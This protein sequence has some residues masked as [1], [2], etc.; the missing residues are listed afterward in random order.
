[1]RELFGPV[2]DPRS[3]QAVAALLERPICAVDVGCRDGVRQQWRALGSHGVLIGFEADSEECAR[4]NA[5]ASEAGSERY[6]PL[7]LAARE[8]PATLHLTADPESASLYPPNTDAIRR[9]PELWRHEPHGSTT[10]Q[11]TTLDRWAQDRPVDVLKVDVQG[12]ELDVLRGGESTLATTRAL[13]VEVEFQ[14]LYV[15]QPLFGDV[16]AFLREHGFV[17]WRLRDIAHCGLTSVGRDEAAFVVGERAET[18]RTGGRVS[19]A[20]A[21]YVRSEA[22]D[23][24]VR[25]DWTASARD[26][27]A[28]VLFDLPELVVLNLERAAEGAQG[29]ARRTLRRQLR[30]ARRRAQRRRLHGLFWEAPRHVRGF[31][32]AR[33]AQS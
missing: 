6:E 29:G 32:G 31:V 25:L 19:W 14:P 8:G 5:S 11:A 1:M 17:L 3:L 10:V 26:A 33:L 12:A 7:V 2:L 24:D 22:A 15:G 9:H 4:L 27:C 28:A 30:K 18:T 13:E 21:V 20:N 23:P 16:D